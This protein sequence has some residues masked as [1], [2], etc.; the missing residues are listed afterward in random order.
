VK[1]TVKSVIEDLE[2]MGEEPVSQLVADHPCPFTY[3]DTSLTEDWTLPD[4]GFEISN[5]KN[6]SSVGLEVVNGGQI[7][8]YVE[9]QC[10]LNN[11]R[12]IIKKKTGSHEH[13]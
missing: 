11:K 12:L 2:E 13:N 1:A 6:Q 7:V 9:I 5:F 10:I 4:H 8:F 3:D